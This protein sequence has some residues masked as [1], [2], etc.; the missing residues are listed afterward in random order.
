LKTG[1]TVGSLA[2][3]V[4][5][6]NPGFRNAAAKDYTLTNGSVCIGAANSAVYGLPGKEYWLN[7]VTNREW[8]IRAAARDIGAFEST[9]TDGPVGPYDVEPRPV[10]SLSPGIGSAVVVWSLFAQDFQLQQS[11]LVTPFAWS[12]VNLALTTNATGVQATVP[13]SVDSL[14]R[15]RR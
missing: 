8:R 12:D 15:L 1:A 4:Q 3:T 10:L 6:A 9:S 11:L 2:G 14:F 7:E 5:S 13:V